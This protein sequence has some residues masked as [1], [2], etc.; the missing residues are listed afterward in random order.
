MDMNRSRELSP[1]LLRRAEL[2][3]GIFTKRQLNNTQSSD[4]GLARAISDG[5]CHRVELGLFSL[6]PLLTARAKLW[7]G[8]LLGG[9]EARLGGEAA[10]FILGIGS[11]PEVVDIWTGRSK[12]RDRSTWRFHPGY[13]PPD[14][15]SDE[16]EPDQDMGALLATRSLT[17]ALISEYA[18]RQLSIRVRQSMLDLAEHECDIGSSVLETRWSK[19]VEGPHGLPPLAWTGPGVNESKLLGGYGD[20]PVQVELRPASTQGRRGSICDTREADWSEGIGATRFGHQITVALDWD[21]VVKRPCEVAE[22]LSRFLIEAG[23]S[24][25]P[26]PCARC[27]RVTHASDW[28]GDCPVDTCPTCGSRLAPFWT[29]LSLPD[30]GNSTD[31]QSC[32]RAGNRGNWP[33]GAGTHVGPHP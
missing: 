9:P 7:A 26:L 29:P 25:H 1:A 31:A 18:G 16:E 5:R 28:G 3:S 24:H 32:R 27:P 33:S 22:G 6:R 10:R 8:L 15:K 17:Q 13:P 14:E 19:D 2:Q 21:D 30:F 23:L 12:R 4:S 11:A 20:A